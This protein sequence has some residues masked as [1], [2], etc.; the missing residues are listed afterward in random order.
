M[1][2]HPKPRRQLAYHQLRLGLPQQKLHSNRPLHP[3]PAVAT[4]CRP[5]PGHRRRYQDRH[6]L[7]HLQRRDP[8]DRRAPRCTSDS[9]S[10]GNAPCRRGS[11]KWWCCWSRRRRRAPP[12]QSSLV[13]SHE[14][15][16]GPSSECLTSRPQCCP[17]AAFLTRGNRSRAESCGVVR[18]RAESDSRI[19]TRYLRDQSSLCG[20]VRHGQRPSG[21]S[22]RFPTTTGIRFGLGRLGA[23][24][25]P[26]RTPA[27]AQKAPRTPADAGPIHSATFG[28]GSCDGLVSSSVIPAT[29]KAPPAMSPTVDIVCQRS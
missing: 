18:S 17:T 27:R 19:H 8:N 11:S 7:R 15:L 12:P 14:S 24:T 29:V 3:L 22:V 16:P 28:F 13:P 1:S 21:P 2:L 23:V 10:R 5:C 26:W 6:P 4:R 25:S 20:I 9:R